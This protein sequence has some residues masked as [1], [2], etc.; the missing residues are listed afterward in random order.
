MKVESTDYDKKIINLENFEDHFIIV[1]FL[2]AGVSKK[3]ELL[4]FNIRRNKKERIETLTLEINTVIKLL[5]DMDSDSL[6]DD[7]KRDFEKCI[8]EG[9]E[10]KDE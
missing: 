5:R 9:V 10:K 3:L 7:I 1:S 8:N 6:A 2:S 4:S